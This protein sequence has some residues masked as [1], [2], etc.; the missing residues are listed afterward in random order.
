MAWSLIYFSFISVFGDGLIVAIGSWL[1]TM[2]ATKV[3]GIE[4]L[5]RASERSAVARLRL[6]SELAGDDTGPSFAICL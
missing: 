2:G 5:N 6:E 4:V 3:F 1:G